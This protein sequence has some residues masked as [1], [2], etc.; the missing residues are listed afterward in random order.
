[1]NG[2]VAI[3]SDTHLGRRRW[4]LPAADV[5][6]PLWQGATHVVVNGDVAELHHPA[7]RAR[8]AREVLRLQEL[9]EADGVTL[10]LLSGNHD[11][12]LSDVRHL[13]LAAGRVFVTHGDALHQAVAPWSPTA[14]ILREAHEAALAAFSP[15]T[16]GHLESVLRASQHAAAAE[17]QLLEEQASHSNLREMLLRPWTWAQVLW[18]WHQFPRLAESFAA[19]HAPQAS[20]FI[21]GH[22]HRR[23]I[24]RFGERVIVNTGSFNFPGRPY[25]VLVEDSGVGIVDVRWRRRARRYEPGQ[26]VA[27]IPLPAAPSA[28][29]TRPGSERPTTPAI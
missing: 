4:G 22:T 11:P 16:R 9:C 14:G 13:H 17:W 29:K 5:L 23:G 24:W 6:R 8:A 25:L 19:T 20:C 15:E 26:T 18:Y 3:F 2:T 12:Y 10:R 7:Y 27:E 21:F 28:A 1:M